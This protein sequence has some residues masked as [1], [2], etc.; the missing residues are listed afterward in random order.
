MQDDDDYQD[1]FDDCCWWWQSRR[2]WCRWSTRPNPKWRRWILTIEMTL[3]MTLKTSLM[4]NLIPKRVPRPNRRWPRQIV[5]NSDGHCFP[6]L[7]IITRRM[8]MVLIKKVPFRCFIF[9]I[10]MIFL[11]IDSVMSKSIWI[12]VPSSKGPH[13]PDNKIHASV[14]IHPCLLINLDKYSDLNLE[15]IYFQIRQKLLPIGENIFPNWIKMCFPYYIYK[16][17]QWSEHFRQ[18][19]VCIHIL[20]G[21]PQLPIWFHSPGTGPTFYRGILIFFQT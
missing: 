21:L 5:T 3:T 4:T 20:Q 10:Y 13:C 16:S 1:G 12:S 14:C 7:V 6:L 17:N 8:E 18:A 19:S 15:K 9:F 2:I 11:T